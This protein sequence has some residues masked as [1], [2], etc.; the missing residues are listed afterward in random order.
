MERLP[1]SVVDKIQSFPEYRMGAQLVDLVLDDGCL[2]ENVV[3]AGD[4]IFTVGGSES[5]NFDP[6]RVVDARNRVG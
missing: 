3:V 2:V 6:G 5:V 4:T 1:E